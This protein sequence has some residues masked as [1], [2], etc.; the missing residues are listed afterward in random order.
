MVRDEI[1][2]SI[3]ATLKVAGEQKRYKK[4]LLEAFDAKAEELITR[5]EKSIYSKEF[6][7]EITTFKEDLLKKSKFEKFIEKTA[8][9]VP[10]LFS[11]VF[12]RIIYK[13][14]KT[15]ENLDILQIYKFELSAIGTLLVIWFL[16]SLFFVFK[17]S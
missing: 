1:K 2:K 4:E 9:F 8:F 12:I 13:L 11:L 5:F 16:A 15:C 10:L 7:Q 17:K 3:V 14:D 6:Q